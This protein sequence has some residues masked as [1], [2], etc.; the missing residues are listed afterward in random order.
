MKRLLLNG[1]PRG[2]GGNSRKILAWMA[3]GMAEAGVEA[4]PTLDLVPDPRRAELVEAF[5]AADE[6]LL[7]FPLYCD[8]L[9]ALVK[10][11]FET[12]ATSNAP[13]LRGKRVAFVIHSGF[14]EG[15]HTETLGRY[16]ARLCQ[17]M[18]FQHLGTLRKGSSEAIHF[19]DSAGLVK[20]AV[21]FRKAGRELAAKG[22]FSPELISRMAGPRTFGPVVRAVLRFLVWTGKID[23][24]WN[25]V[26]KKN[27]AFD[28]RFDTP[29]APRVP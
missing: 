13:S 7:A 22:R 8:S 3:E 1:S 27:G 12:L 24:F 5:L 26:L 18:G 6:V 4:M 23:D 20:A 25:R 21:P 19:M 16:L 2:K 29:Y 10:T 15:I 17:R 9:P 28:R 14:P 11:F